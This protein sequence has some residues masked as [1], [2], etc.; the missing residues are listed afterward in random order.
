MGGLVRVAC[1][2]TIFSLLFVSILGGPLYAAAVGETALAGTGEIDGP[3]YLSL[4]VSPPIAS[5]RDSVVVELLASNR[6]EQAAAPE[7]I[8]ALPSSLS[9]AESRFPSGT[10]FNF[11]N[12]SLTWRPLL[13]AQG[14]TAQLRLPFDVATADLTHPEQIVQASLSAGG[15]SASTEVTLWV[16][17]PPT[18]SIRL[19]PPVAAVGEPIQLVA[20]PTGPGPFTQSWALGDGRIVG[21]KDPVVVYPA[22]GTYEVVVQVANPLAITTASA[23]V[24]IV[25]QPSA[26]FSLDD[27]RVAVGEAVTFVNNS[28]GAPPLQYIWDFGDGATSVEPNPTHQYSA[29]GNYLV[30]LMVQSEFGQAQTSLPVAVGPAPAAEVALAGETVT[31]ELFGGQAATDPTVT[32]L[33]WDTGDGHIYEGQAFTHVYRETGDYLVTLTASNDFGAV[34]RTQWVHVGPGV[35]GVF[36]PLL[37]S[38]SYQLAVAPAAGAEGTPITA[39]QPEAVAVAPA[40]TPVAQGGAGVTLGESITETITVSETVALTGTVAITATTPLSPTEAP[41][42]PAAEAPPAPAPVPQP[43]PPAEVL[44]ENIPVVALPAQPALPEG[45]S[46]AEQ[47]YWYINEARRLHGLPPLAYNYEL[48]V[49]AQLHTVDTTQNPEIMHDG[50]D[51]S[52]PAERQRRHGYDGIYGGE[53]I[54]WGWETPAS[55]VE[56]WVNSPPHRALILNPD[57][58]EVGVGYVADGNAPNLWYWTAEFGIRLEPPPE[59][60]P[61][62]SP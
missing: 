62:P 9:F 53:A 7:I 30:Q 31:G 17:L 5:P 38:N 22:P 55:A 15:Q 16:G 36:M 25:P 42:A 43:A 54:A 19:S 4:T 60:A 41:P 61:P 56:F 57:A 8:L 11:Q 18:A 33:R 40:P 10:T 21:V 28:G 34:E 3:V 12:S 6:Q 13:A 2:I 26:A 47:L 51:G 45:S 48:S 39:A 58:R 37:M 52:T 50:S 44:S 59:I 1:L 46:A 14:G 24:T 49:A 29:P 27:Q 35:F 23:F 20:T 32:D